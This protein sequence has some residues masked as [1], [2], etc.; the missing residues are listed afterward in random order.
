MVFIQIELIQLGETIGVHTKQKN[1]IGFL[2]P[3]LKRAAILRKYANYQSHSPLFA[4]SSK[5]INWKSRRITGL[6][7]VN[8]RWNRRS[9]PFPKVI[10]NCCYGDKEPY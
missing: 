4:F 5:S 3:T 9:F 10:Y 7:Y 2:V 8:G 6:E 1:Y